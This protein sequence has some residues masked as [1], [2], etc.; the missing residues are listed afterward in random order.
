M[1]N[2]KN[3]AVIGS[4]SI[5]EQYLTNMINFYKNL[6]VVGCSASNIEHAKKRAAQ[7]NIKAMTN[8]EIFAD[9]SIDIV[10]ILVPTPVH[11]TLIEQALNAGKHVYTEKTI[12]ENTKDAARLLKLA[13]EKGLYLGSAPDT[14][15]GAALQEARR[16]LDEGTIGEPLSFSLNINR[17]VEFLAS[18][19]NFLRM[20]GGGL[21]Y[22]YGVYYFTALVSLLGPVKDVFS[23]VKNLSKERT[24]VFPQS[25]DFGKKY[26][27]NNESQLYALLNL[28]SGIT[29]TVSMNGDS[30]IMDI[31]YFYIYGTKGILKLSCANDFGGDLEVTLNPEGFN[32][33]PV[34]TFKGSSPITGE[35][36]GI[37]P[38]E[39]ALAIDEKRPNRASKEMAYHVL[40]LIETI[41]KSSNEK[42]C[43]EVASTCKIPA[44][45]TDDVIAKLI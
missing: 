37:G 16:I 5:S 6:N 24:N 38:A 3:V 44:P 33:P 12:S 4:G 8:E 19:F 45:L 32:P 42:K 11:A 41:M 17:N 2:K 31:P 28:E 14:F 39:M 23:V 34:K 26:E 1:E 40:D 9:P 22:D 7:F 20:P 13:D 25:P 35:K 36:R 43:L 10:V 29:G 21:A 27:Y 30:V 18:I 15:M